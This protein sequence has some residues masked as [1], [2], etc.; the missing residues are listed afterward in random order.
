MFEVKGNHPGNSENR[1]NA[2]MG[3]QK[4]SCVFHFKLRRDLW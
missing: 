3:P 4:R 2:V 1:L